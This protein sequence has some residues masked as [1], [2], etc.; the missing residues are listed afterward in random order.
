M[1]IKKVSI[2]WKIYKQLFNRIFRAFSVILNNNI[3]WRVS[4]RQ[5]SAE[6]NF[7][8]P[9]QLFLGLRHTSD[10]NFIEIR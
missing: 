3:N 2:L 6:I 10:K 8:K 4:Q 7:C 5:N 1:S 9:G